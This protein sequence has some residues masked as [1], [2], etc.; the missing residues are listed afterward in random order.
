MAGRKQFV[1]VG[2]SNSSLLDILIGVPQ[3]SILGPLLFLI[4]INDLP[5][6]SKLFSQLF[7]DD[8]TQS[9]SH[10]N[11]DI[12][13][14]FVNTEFKKTVNF[15]CAHRLS[16]HPE[17]TKF[18]LVSHSK[19]NIVPN[20]QINYNPIGGIHDPQKIIKM[21]FINNSFTPYAKFLGFLIDPHLTFK[22]KLNQSPKKYQLHFI[23]FEMQKI[24]YMRKP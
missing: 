9:S 7:A 3:G 12:L 10:S 2:D 18:M 15:F 24:Y 22:I 5:R 13:T 16:L 21:N 19:T 4:Y 23:F 17:K 11:L 1:N 6:C 14:D 20:I 8:T